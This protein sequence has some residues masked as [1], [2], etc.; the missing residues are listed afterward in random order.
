M[1]N[2]TVLVALA[3]LLAM[4]ASPALA[5][6]GRQ[7]SAVGCRAVDGVAQDLRTY[8]IDVSMSTDSLSTATQQAWNI[9]AITDSTT[10]AFVSDSAQC[11]QAARVLAAAQ[12]GDT[13]NPAPVN[14]LSVGTTRYV[15]FNGYMAGEFFVRYVLDTGFHVLAAF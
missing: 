3:S 14:L 10:I 2:A 12:R 9:P 8:V 6:D 13:L 4:I 15:A 5:K 7:V 1:R 11:A